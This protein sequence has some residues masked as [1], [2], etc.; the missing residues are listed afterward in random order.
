MAVCVAMHGGLGASHSLSTSDML[1]PSDD[2]A[3]NLDPINTRVQIFIHEPTNRYIFSS[4]NIQ[5]VSNLG[6]R[7]GVVGWA[8]DTLDSLA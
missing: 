1:H 2:I 5:A 7:L 4:Y 3:T 6:A 8:Y